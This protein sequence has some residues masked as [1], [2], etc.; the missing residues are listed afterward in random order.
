MKRRSIVFTALKKAEIIESE[1]ETR[2]PD[3]GYAL[4]KTDYTLISPGTER[5]NL[6]GLVDGKFPKTLGY[7]AIATV[8]E[9]GEG[10]ELEPGD[11]TVIYH[12]VHSN[13]QVKEERDIV[14]IED[15]SIDA[16]DAIFVVTAAM[17]LQ[18]VR[19]VRP[20]LGE[21]GAVMGLG[22]LGLAAIQCL[23][24][25]GVFPL[26][27]IDFNAKRRAIAKKF[28]ADF[29]FSP[30][31][32]ELRQKIRE[33][34]EGGVNSLIEVTGNPE[35]LNMALDLMAPLGRVALVGCSRFPTKEID[36]Y[37]KVHKPGISIIGGH[38][39]VRPK[40]DSY[41]GYWT[42]RRDMA[43]LLRMIAIGKFTPSVMLDQVLT[44]EEGP[45]IFSKLADG[46]LDSLG[47]MFDWRNDN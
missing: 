31:E 15:P 34:T 43:M 44:P 27:A 29:T 14:R 23:S 17:G 46:K 36:F 16:K 47:I 38:N 26:I 11:R 13:Y 30:D 19:K 42:M 1:L 5:A 2:K 20:E 40:N 32:A 21:S 8:I 45:A 39:F 35:A 6:L 41:P 3:P 10:S 37:H 18:G 4:L 28:G 9:A 12:S 33:L 25:S 22:L 7:S 24:L